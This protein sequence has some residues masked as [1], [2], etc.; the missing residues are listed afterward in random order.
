MLEGD[1]RSICKPE[2][3]LDSNYRTIRN[4]LARV[5]D[6]LLQLGEYLA[7]TKIYRAC[8]NRKPKILVP[9]NLKIYNLWAPISAA[10]KCK[11]TNLKQSVNRKLPGLAGGLKRTTTLRAGEEAKALRCGSIGFTPPPDL[12]NQSYPRMSTKSSGSP[13]YHISSLSTA[14][15]TNALLLNFSAL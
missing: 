15:C 14:R 2:N 9:R 11:K 1:H 13:I 7:S 6:Q 12:G 10:K 5:V 8:P 3:E 4:H